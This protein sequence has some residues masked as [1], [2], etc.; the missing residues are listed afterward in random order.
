MRKPRVIGA[1]CHGLWI[2]TPSPDMLKGRTVLCSLVVLAGILNCGANA[3][4]NLKVV[5]DNELVNGLEQTRSASLHSGRRCA[6]RVVSEGD[7]HAG[8]STKKKD[9]VRSIG[10]GVLGGR[11]DRTLRGFERCRLCNRVRYAK[12]KAPCC[13]AAQYGTGI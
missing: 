10:M 13:A 8:I 4:M 1:L 6:G 3:V 2:L 11:A 12:W 5:V 7:H 9:S